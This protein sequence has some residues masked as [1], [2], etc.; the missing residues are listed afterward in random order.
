MLLIH[1]QIV[2]KHHSKMMNKNITLLFC[3]QNKELLM[4]NEEMRIRDLISIKMENLLDSDKRN[5][6]ETEKNDAQIEKE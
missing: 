1:G 5:L 4:E 2:K 3:D 6:T